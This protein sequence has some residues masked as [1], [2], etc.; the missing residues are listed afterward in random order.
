MLEKLIVVVEEPS[1]EAMLELL[2][3]KLIDGVD[4]EIKPFQ[5]KDDLLKNLPARL[6]GYGK[7]LPESWAIVVLV[8]RDDDDCRLLRR[9]LDD[10]AERAGLMSKTRAGK[11][12]RFQIANRI[13]VEELEAWFFGDWVAVQEAYPRVPAKI[14]RQAA[15]R[16]PDGVRGGTW[17]ALERILQRSGYVTTGLRKIECARK[18][19]RHMQPDRNSSASFRAFVGAVSAT[20]AL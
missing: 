18:V 20:M 19:A 6:R 1:M 4:F 5:C 14:P 12:H 16:D 7:W 17:E 3:P 9:K 8:D 10:M 15:Y 13:A 11:G 2:L